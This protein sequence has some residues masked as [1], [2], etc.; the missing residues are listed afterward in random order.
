M[1][2]VGPPPSP[3]ADARPATRTDRAERWL[4][5][6]LAAVL[7]AGS[8]WLFTRANTFPHEYHPDEPGK[9]PQVLEGRRNYRHP[10]LLLETATLLSAVRGEMAGLPSRPKV[11]ALPDGRER[12]QRAVE[13]GRD[14][15]AFFAAGA[16]ALLALTA[17]QSAGLAALLLCGVGLVGCGPL[18]V[19]AHFMKE[20]AALVFGLSAV[21]LAG[22]VAWER[23]GADLPAR[24]RTAGLLGA[25]CALAVSGKY[26]GIV[27]V[28]PAVW[29]LLPRGTPPADRRQLLGRFA[30]GLAVVVLCVNWRVVKNLPTFV[31]AIGGQVADG[32]VEHKGL[33]MAKPTPFFAAAVAESVPAYVLLPA[34]VAAVAGSMAAR[35]GDRWAAAV[36]LAPIAYLAFVSFSSAPNHRHVLPVVVLGYLSAAVLVGAALSK[37]PKPRLL[38]PALAVPLAVAVGLLHAPRAAAHIAQFADDSRGRAARWVDD[39]LPDDAVVLQDAAAELHLSDASPAADGRDE[40]GRVVT[41]EFAPEMGPLEG[42]PASGV[43]HVAVCDVAYGRYFDPHIVPVPEF[44]PEYDRRRAWYDRLFREGRLVWEAQPIAPTYAVTSPTVRVYELPNAAE[45]QDKSG[46]PIRE[47]SGSE[48]SST[49]SPAP[50]RG[51]P[52]AAVP[53]PGGAAAP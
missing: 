20:D 9:G 2:D 46:T 35:R 7:F 26:V 31:R 24:L 27:A 22:R 17:Y 18:L 3:S 12:V 11:S 15:S 40:D 34:G 21:T 30:V 39:Q 29:L 42:L 47:T 37:L 32:V 52:S 45:V 51:R 6:A 1:N 43:T 14:V 36:G 44:R 53:S 48:T 41:R 13:T 33:T 25:A 4:A 50:H 28:L 49:G 19:N 23:R 16:V 38:A 8:L 5:A 10:Q